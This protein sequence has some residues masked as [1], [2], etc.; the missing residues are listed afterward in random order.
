MK[1]SL[2]KRSAACWRETC[3]KRRYK[4]RNVCWFPR[5]LRGCEGAGAQN[6]STTMWTPLWNE[7]CQKVPLHADEKH[8]LREGTK[9]V[10]FVDSLWGFKGGAGT[11]NR[12]DR[13]WTS[14]WNEVCQN[15]P[16]HAD[17]KHALREGTKFV[18]FVDS[19]GCQLEH[20]IDEK[21]WERPYEIKCAKKVRL[22]TDQK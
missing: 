2:S 3:V 11:H 9:F 5:G 22:D 19:L 17:E 21:L 7:V 20:K 10:M 13:M 12:S 18:M 15:V 8:A 4:V 6:K 16:L 14:L 1:W